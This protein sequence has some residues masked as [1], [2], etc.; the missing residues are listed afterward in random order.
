MKQCSM[1]HQDKPLTAFYKKYRNKDG[2]EKK[3]KECR[4]TQR[5]TYRA[6]HP[7]EA[8][9]RAKA[10]WTKV[11]DNG[12]YSEWR[13][14]YRD[15][16]SD[17]IYEKNL[18]R[19]FNITK[20]QY[21]AL[22]EAQGGVCAICKGTSG[23]KRFA[24]DHDHSCCPDIGTSCGKCIRGL[25]CSACNTALGS[26]RDDPAILWSAIHYLGDNVSQRVTDVH[27][28]FNALNDGG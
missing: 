11:R 12:T 25:L 4:N 8:K 26:F 19:R 6:N 1:C 24:V 17:S 2:Y 20:A 22:L 3:C 9:A 23:T 5:Q 28:F 13:R 16:N 21:D 27:N 14:D 10:E 15:K 7:E 18:Q